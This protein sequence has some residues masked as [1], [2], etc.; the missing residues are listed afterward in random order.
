MG[1][2]QVRQVCAAHHQR[3]ARRGG[4]GPGAEPDQFGEWDGVDGWRGAAAV[5]QHVP[6]LPV[7]PCQDYTRYTPIIC[8]H[9]VAPSPFILSYNYGTRLCHDQ[10]C[11]F[12]CSLLSPLQSL[13]QALFSKRITDCDGQLLSGE[14]HKAGAQNSVEDDN[15]LHVNY[16]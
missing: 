1:V 14:G 10:D 12:S 13:R 9:S 16:R 7:T 8:Q 3:H 11:L 5:T 4:G 2:L 15:F 6:F